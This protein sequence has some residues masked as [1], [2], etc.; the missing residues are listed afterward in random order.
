MNNIKVQYRQAWQ[1]AY[2]QLNKNQKLAV[3]T[4]EGPV[5]TI[6]GPGTGKTQLLAVRI[7]NILDKTDTSSHN[8]LCLTYTDAGVIAMRQ[9]LESFMGSD[10]YNVNIHTFHAF[11][12]AVIKEN[13]P[14]FG[15]FR[16]LQP[17]SDVE[18]VEIYR[19]L[20][21]KFDDDHALKRLKGDEYNDEVRLKNLFALMKQ[22]K[23]TP[24]VIMNACT[25]HEEIILDPLRSPHVYKKKTTDKN[26]GKVH[27][28][29]DLKLHIIGPEI[30]KFNKVA[31]ASFEI[32]EYNR[33]MRE[34]ERY[35]YQDMILFVIDK[36]QKNSD[37]L[38]KYQ[39]RFLYI[40]V[41]EYQDTNGAQN[42]LLFQLADYWESPNLFI[43]GDDD[44]S[45]FR[46][47]GANMN[48]ILDFKKKYDPVE[49]VLTDNYRSSQI[50]LDRAKNLIEN[51]EERLVH[52]YPYL[53]KDL[54][55]SRLEKPHFSPE[56]EIL[57][58][59]NE[60][61]EE[62]GIIMKIDDLH[63]QGVAYRDIA[64]IYT[65]HR[66]AENLV[67]YFSQKKI[68]INV[69]KRVNV[70]Y[71]NEV[72]RITTILDYLEAEY[73]KP[74]TSEDLLFEILHYDFFGLTAL[75]IAAVTIYCRKKSDNDHEK[76]PYHKWREVIND[77]EKL[78][79][80]GVIHIDELLKVS[81]IIEIWL[82]NIANVT[83]QT[84]IEKIL[85]ES[86]LLHNILS[87]S[88]KAWKLQLVNTFFDF[89]KN[90]A[91]KARQFT[92]R[93]A[94]SLIRLM[95]DTKIELPVYRIINSENGINFLTAYSAKGLEFDH[96]FII[97]CNKN[98]WEDK[99]NG[100][101]NFPLPP[102]LTSSTKENSEEDDR[103]LF[104]V[105][106]TRAKDY[107]YISYPEYNDAEKANPASKFVAEIKKSDAEVIHVR[108]DDTKVINYKA[109][110]MKYKLGEARLIDD[111]LVDKILENFKISA[112]SLNKYLKC[113][114]AFY[115]ENILRV[116][117]GRSAS[118]GFG[119]AIH[120]ALEQF[121]RDIEKVQPRS[122]ASA[123]K[124]KEYF[125]KGIDMYKSH[126]TLQEFDN[127]SKHGE[128]V[129]NE[130]YEKYNAEWLSPVKYE[131]EYSI[132]STEYKGVP[133]SGK[134]DRI[135]V[136]ADHISVT[137]YKTGKYDTTKLKVPKDAEKDPGGD[138]WRQ[139]IFY[140]LLLD[141]DKRNHWL[142]L[143][144]TMDFVEKDNQKVFRKQE[145]KISNP[146]LEIVGNQL[147][148]AYNEIKSHIFTPGCGDEKCQ[149]CNFVM[150]NM[151]AKTV[152]SDQDT[153]DNFEFIADIN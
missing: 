26:T 85:T 150:R 3:D 2:Y 57:C 1:N 46:F 44:Q 119:N 153:E 28:V 146:E 79:S 135:N 39:E 20:I 65:K 7:G 60:A 148:T 41:D 111:D 137:D 66:S 51:N 31:A 147:V 19:K 77:K 22:E 24:E 94:V 37:L 32:E 5:M 105:A 75:D 54:Q 141:G 62:A 99:K 73:S 33:L 40:L 74:H 76:N 96:V 36:F 112:T 104:Y 118:M 30:E 42:E 69:K 132:P 126:F 55:E 100:N 61:Q 45:I 92:L 29:G 107:L 90:E 102:T 128:N 6:A 70:L 101:N 129:L 106:M 97:R 14:Y 59:L 21:A 58:Y 50:I 114:L 116:P 53:I 139:I 43:V 9:R 82:S 95:K 71:E 81:G 136:Y 130:Y 27:E 17:T 131:L 11:C 140:R 108:I 25:A 142:M 8:I 83:I 149:W 152:Q 93:D 72:L 98:M 47:Q 56:P 34:K 122:M 91:A 88:D 117:M 124:L 78:K 138:Y 103:R 120:F 109:E 18:E 64:I 125:S 67:R 63:H 13:L 145:F 89:I 121:F 84:L 144:G 110:L 10:A 113:K 23:W 49:I 143:K 134:L 123:G 16:D 38:A 4:I 15:D 80:A 48:S 127:L 87:G 12:N 133:I 86:N 151:P 68:P 115:F 52:K 35:D